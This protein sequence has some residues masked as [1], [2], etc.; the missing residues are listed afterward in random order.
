MEAKKHATRNRANRRVVLW[1]KE[2]LTH[3]SLQQAMCELEG[4]A[5]CVLLPAGRQRCSFDSCFCRTGDHVLMTN[6]AY[7]LRSGFL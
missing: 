3:F 5:G 1:T 6:T 7:K 4:S 2:H